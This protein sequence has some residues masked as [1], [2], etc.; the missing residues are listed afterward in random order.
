MKEKNN[1]NENFSPVNDNKCF[2]C[3]LILDTQTAT[4][5]ATKNIFSFICFKYDGRHLMHF[6]VQRNRICP[7]CDTMALPSSSSSGL[8]LLV[9]LTFYIQSQL[10][11]F[12]PTLFIS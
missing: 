1:N 4:A 7:I 6:H 3:T 11:S 5:A 2:N 8:L 9:L 12:S 10:S